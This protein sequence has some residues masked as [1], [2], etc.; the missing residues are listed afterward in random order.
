MYDFFL[1]L[2]LII[3]VYI[4][5][6]QVKTQNIHRL[7]AY[8]VTFLRNCPISISSSNTSFRAYEDSF[9]TQDLITKPRTKYIFTTTFNALYNDVRGLY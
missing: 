2:L 7:M 9:S 6:N 1:H 4:T 5:L 8:L 3:Q